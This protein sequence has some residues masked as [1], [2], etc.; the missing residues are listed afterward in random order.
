MAPDLDD[1]AESEVAHQ[2]SNKKFNLF[3]FTI[4]IYVLTVSL[5][6]FKWALVWVGTPDI[7]KQLEFIILDTLGKCLGFTIGSLMVG[8]LL[9]LVTQILLFVVRLFYPAEKN[10][11][12]PL[13]A[14][15]FGCFLS[16]FVSTFTPLL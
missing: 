15:K 12:Y 11:K 1:V 8:G 9:Y 3:T 10:M 14:F 5:R 13:W 4:K 7:A 6:L 16:V 2:L